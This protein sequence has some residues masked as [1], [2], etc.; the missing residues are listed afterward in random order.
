MTENLKRGKTK[1]LRVKRKLA[2][3]ILLEATRNVR[4]SENIFWCSSPLISNFLDRRD[5]FMSNWKPF[6]NC[7]NTFLKY[8]F[9]TWQ[10]HNFYNPPFAVG[11]LPK[12]VEFFWKGGRIL[13]FNL[14]NKGKP[15][16]RQSPK[17]WRTSGS[18]YRNLNSQTGL[19]KI[20]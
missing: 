14:R 17:P 3:K 7:P 20:W 18:Q 4:L 5:I 15:A 1:K 16:Q 13:T 6:A 11:F 8:L 2:E 9:S 10:L 19:K 12:E